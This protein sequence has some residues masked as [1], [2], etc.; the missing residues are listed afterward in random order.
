[1]DDY[2]SKPVRS[3]ALAEVLER[4]IPADDGC[5]TNGGPPARDGRRIA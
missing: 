1:M 4:W 3:Q 5:E 2:L